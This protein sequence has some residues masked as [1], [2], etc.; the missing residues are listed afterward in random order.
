MA[1]DL[2]TEFIRARFAQLEQR[3]DEQTRDLRERL[4]ELKSAQSE[5]A[6]L[7]VARLD[8]ME[9]RDEANAAAL[10]AHEAYHRENEHRWGLVRLAGRHPFRFVA[11]AVGCLAALGA[12]DSDFAR[13]L[14][15]RFLTLK[16]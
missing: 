11:L 14:I 7:V 2:F 10:R 16:P 15:D 8:A 13:W 6:A 4:D 5:L 9:A 1:D 12:V 3:L